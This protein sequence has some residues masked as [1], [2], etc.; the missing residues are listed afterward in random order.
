MDGIGPQLPLQKNQT[1]GHY[2]IITSYT[3]EVRQNFKNLVLTSPGERVMD[4]SFGIGLRTFLF[5]PAPTVIPKIRKRIQ[6]QV[7]KYMPFIRITKLLFNEGINNDFANDSLIVKITIQYD[8]PSLNL[9]SEL[10][11]QGED[12]N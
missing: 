5:E 2:G 3:E 12:I 11:L 8:V 7:A 9:S 1:H 6:E 10:R 4:P